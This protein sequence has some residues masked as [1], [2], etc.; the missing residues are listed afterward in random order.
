MPSTP[1]PLSQPRTRKRATSTPA[2]ALA[3]QAVDAVLDKKAVDVV[4]MDMRDVSGVADFFVICTG[5]SDRQIKAVAEAVREQVR[6][7][8]GELPWHTEGLDHLQW[9]L[10]D[11]VDVVVHVFEAEKRAF[12][13]LERLW[14]D[15]PSEPVP[16]GGRAADIALLRRASAAETAG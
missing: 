3:A 12:Y 2:H 8:S 1:K 6:E 9:V 4:V 5:E 7:A 13:D 10:L 14:G 16:E 11:Y 15:A